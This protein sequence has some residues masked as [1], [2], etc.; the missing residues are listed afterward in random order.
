MA[1]SA[2]NDTS[3][4]D[5]LPR[6]GLGD[7]A[8]GWALAYV[9]ASV[10]FVLIA[11]GLGYTN[12]QINADALP[13]WVIALS[14]PPLWLGFVGVPLW[15]ARA[16][17][18]GI[19]ADFRA[20]FEWVDIPIG[21]VAGAVAQYVLV[22]LVSLPVLLLTGK[23]RADLGKPAHD[24]AAK[25]HGGWGIALFVVIVVIGA[26]L[27]EELFFRGLVLRAIEKRFTIGWAVAG[28]AVIFGATHFEALQ[29]VALAAAGLVFAALVVR[30]DRL[31]PAIVAH[32]TFNGIAVA[33][34][35]H[36]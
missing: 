6:W 2:P 34:L 18:S 27:A 5:R 11:G 25:A 32:M 10:A 23:T 30:T 29:F 14:Y 19:V 28:S 22:P 17:G 15:A 31:G 20:R 16:K 3:A 1:V 7:A 36:R 13:L 26:P 24:L 9:V 33:G 12:A 4:S 35:V 21:L 8:V